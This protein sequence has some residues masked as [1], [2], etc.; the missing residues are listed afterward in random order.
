MEYS[1]SL[2]FSHRFFHNT[3]IFLQGTTSSCGS[4]LAQNF[5]GKRF[6]Y[7][8]E[9]PP[10]SP[11]CNPLDYFIWNKIKTEVNRD[12]LNNLL[13]DEE[14]LKQKNK[15]V[16]KDVLFVLPEMSWI[17]FKEFE[18]HAWTVSQLASF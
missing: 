12:Q 6:V 11:D 18:K 8:T 17:S 16:L 3:W 15:N 2:S 10:S 14:E 7:K 1:S 5:L 13:K 9:W 4:S